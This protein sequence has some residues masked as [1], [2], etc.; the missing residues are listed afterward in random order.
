MQRQRH[1]RHAVGAGRRGLDLR[2]LLA[3]RFVAIHSAVRGGQQGF[4]AVAV[5]RIDRRAD[6]DRQRQAASGPRLEQHFVDRILEL[7]AL[8]LGFVG[9]AAREHDDE[10]IAGVA[11]ADVVRP[12]AGAQHRGH[13]PQR[14]IADVVA[15]V[16]VDRLEV[17]EVHH[18]Q[19]DLGLQ[20]FG[21]RQLA[22][23]VHEH[24]A[25]IRQAGQRIGQRIFLRLLEHDRVVDDGRG[26]L[27]DA[28]E[29]PAVV[30]GVEIRL[31][32]IHG[33]CADEA[34]AEHQRRHQRG[35]QGR[36]LR[37]TRGF[38]LR[39]RPRVHQRAAVARNPA[40]QTLARAHRHGADRIGFDAGREAAAQRVGFLVVQEQRARRERH[41]VRQLRRDQ[42]HRVGNA[43]AGAHRLRDFIQR[44]DFAVRECD[45]FEH[46][47]DLVGLW[48]EADCGPA[49]LVLRLERQA[50]RRRSLDRLS[51]RFHFRRHLDEHLHDLRIERA[52]RFLLE[53][54]HGGLW[55]HRLVVWPIRGQR[56]VVVDHRKDS[57]PQRNLLA[58]DSLRVSL[59]VP[60]FVVAQDQRRHWIRE[61]HGADDLG[62]DL[63]MDADLLEL[64][65]RQRSR[66]RQNVLGHR[67]LA[68]VVEQGGGL[69]TL[70]FGVGHAEA[71]RDAGGVDLDAADMRLRGLILGIDGE[72]ERFD[73]GEVQVRHFLDVTTFVVD[74]P[75]IDLVTAISHIQRRGG[76]QREPHT[77]RHQRPGADG[78]GAGADEVTRAAPE[79]ILVPHRHERLFG[80]ERDRHGDQTRIENEVRRGGADE[81]AGETGHI[82][83]QRS[84][85]TAEVF[86]G[87]A[88]CLHRDRQARH[89]EQRAVERVLGLHPERALAPGARHRDQHR[90]VGAEQQ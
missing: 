64:F 87:E 13:F 54:R 41:E 6:A 78:G 72:R 47:A 75:K 31:G 14:A 82:V 9:A 12:D 50:S 53:Q 42:R 63:R 45:V 83:R 29:Q 20:P 80:G 52:A 86:V 30:V 57:R 56:I 32:R 43:E 44:V 90:F 58:L 19:G 39:A 35:L 11:D 48:R 81:R 28:I 62:A 37:Q 1:G 40:G 69:H 65:L 7:D 60:A 5:L 73:R 10:F 17:V 21:S 22:G 71:A 34:I 16:V 23:Q 76:Q 38:E 26:L 70:D 15:V 2:A 55:G 84:G 8:A 67:E 51:G 4:V 46:R 36:G 59:A 77:G 68:D 79:E 88:G 66:L 33:E 49:E 74:A 25:R 85:Y 18:Q 27:A 24:E 89:A 3:A 61:R